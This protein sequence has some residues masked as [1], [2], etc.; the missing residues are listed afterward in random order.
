MEAYRIARKYEEGFGF[1]RYVLYAFHE[2]VRGA[3]QDNLEAL[4][5]VIIYLNEFERDPSQSV[6]DAHSHLEE[7]SRTRL[8]RDEHAGN[9]GEY[10]RRIQLSIRPRLAARV[11][12]I[13]NDEVRALAKGA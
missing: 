10:F 9:L 11:A 12:S 8:V 1:E 3:K 4:R 2:A 7:I 6:M 13:W 5:G